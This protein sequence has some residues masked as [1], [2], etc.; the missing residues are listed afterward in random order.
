MSWICLFPQ[1]AP[2]VNVTHVKFCQYTSSPTTS[3]QK[4][5]CAIDNIQTGQKHQSL[6][7]WNNKLPLFSV[8]THPPKPM[9]RSLFVNSYASEPSN[10]LSNQ[11][12]SFGRN[13]E[14][15]RC[16]GISPWVTHISSAELQVEY[17]PPQS[18]QLRA[19]EL[20][21]FEMSSIRRPAI[22]YIQQ[23]QTNW[24]IS[25]QML[26][27]LQGSMGKFRW[28]HFIRRT[29]TVCRMMKK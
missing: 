19:N 17:F 2:L 24:R 15:H 4:Q 9:Q 28:I 6:S 14:T 23:R 29:W 7:T 5:H 11:H 20:S 21:P 16:S 13:R 1:T 10:L 26:E 8:V 27:F 25:T 12:V 3:C 22:D 18:T